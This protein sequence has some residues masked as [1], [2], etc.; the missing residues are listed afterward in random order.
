MTPTPLRAALASVC[1]RG[2]AL[3]RHSARESQ[4]SALVAKK[5]KLLLAKRPSRMTPL[6]L[7]TT[8]FRVAATIKVK[9]NLVNVLVSV[10]DDDNRPAADL[11][12]EAFQIIE[13]G[14]PQ[15]LK[16]SNAKPSSRSTW[17]S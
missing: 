7:Q 15:K 3:L 12:V 8:L 6:W 16:F 5:T 11:P 9:V 2:F 13:E 17:R 14:K 4:S 10:L 1:S